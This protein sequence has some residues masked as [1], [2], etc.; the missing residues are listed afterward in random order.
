MPR[1]TAR[2]LKLAVLADLGFS[3]TP[4]LAV[5]SR[6]RATSAELDGIGAA[7][8][9]CK[10]PG[11]FSEAADFVFEAWEGVGADEPHGNTQ[12]YVLHFL[13]D[14]DAYCLQNGFTVTNPTL[15]EA[16]YFGAWPERNGSA[17]IPLDVAARVWA[18]A[19]S[20]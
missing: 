16:V 2:G 5:A 20:Y 11:H 3:Q 14:M 10:L 9:P 8:C 19:F 7:C 4:F 18:I 17:P 6:G 15:R 12:R 13:A 1:T